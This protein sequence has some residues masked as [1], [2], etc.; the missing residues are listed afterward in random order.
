MG[1]GPAWISLVTQQAAWNHMSASAYV[2]RLI[3]KDVRE[4]AKNMGA[5]HPGPRGALAGGDPGSKLGIEG[6]PQK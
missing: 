2:H 4:Q 1:W 3:E 6:Q 5:L